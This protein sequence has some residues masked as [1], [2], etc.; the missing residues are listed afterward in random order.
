MVTKAHQFEYQPGDLQPFVQISPIKHGDFPLPAMLLYRTVRQLWT[1]TCRVFSSSWSTDIDQTKPL[2]R[3]PQNG[4]EKYRRSPHAQT[5]LIKELYSYP[6]TDPWKSGIFMCVYLHLI[7]V[8]NTFHWWI[9]TIHGSVMGFSYF[10]PFLY[11]SP[12]KAIC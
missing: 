1:K 6:M 12:F 4:G 7:D 9:N 11:S 3:K 2:I 8:Y 5:I 10:S